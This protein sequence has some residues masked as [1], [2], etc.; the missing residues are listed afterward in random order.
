MEFMNE[1]SLSV[2]DKRN[3]PQSGSA[4]KL[5]SRW[6][7]LRERLRKTFPFLSGVLAA[8]LALFLFNTFFPGAKPLTHSEVDA[9]ISSAMASATPRPAEG[10][11]V[12]QIIQPSLV[13]IET[14]GVDDAGKASR[15]LGS[16]V[17][18]DQ[19][20]NILT[21]L[22]V[23]DGAPTINVTFADGTHSRA[24]IADAQ[25]EM[26]IAVLQAATLPELFLP[27]TLG[28]AGSLQV[29]DEAF[30]VGNPY[31]LYGSMSAG[32]ISGFNRTFQPPGTNQTI[33]GL[34]QVD[35]AINPGNSGG[36]LLN[37]YGHVVGIV[38]GIINPTDESFFVGIGFA[39]PI[40]V[41]AGGGGSPPY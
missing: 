14:D 7:R 40:N 24:V 3:T 18:F 20:G 19:D 41:A 12:Y 27:A 26:D 9:A 21:S 36:P 16:G 28:N 32:V 2:G 25:P 17:I 22:H 34:I 38:T 6:A 30:V 35:A 29:G 1:P 13:W 11:L 31:G 37:R 4:D 33:E 10:V 5:R 39:V 15:G 8:L 23:V